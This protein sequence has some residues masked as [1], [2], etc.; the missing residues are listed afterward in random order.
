MIAARFEIRLPEDTWIADV[1]RAAPD[2]TF[3]LLSGVR[4]GETAIELGET[5]AHDPAPIG[6]A[7]AAHR[8]IVAYEAL[9]VTDDR[10]LAKYETTDTALYEFVAASSV[11]IEYPVVVEDGWYEFDLTTTREEFDRFV[12]AIEET[13]RHYE[14]LSLVHSADGAGLLTE[15][16]REVLA[17]ALRNGYF[18]VPRDC[19]LADLAAALDVDKSTASRILRRGQSRIVRW[20]LT[21]SDSPV[22]RSAER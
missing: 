1:S 21:S 20:F 14:L 2:A 10:A 6:D 12:A 22:P 8:S 9:E 13:G 19:A 18:A 17:V 7:I 5:V 16:Q 4:A 15:R 11:P 3:R